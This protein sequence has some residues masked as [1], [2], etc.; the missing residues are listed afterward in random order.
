MLRRKLAKEFEIE[1]LGEL[2]YFLGMEVARLKKEIFV[3]QRKYVLDLLRET[4]MS[5]CRPADMSIDPKSEVR[6]CETEN[7]C[8][9]SAIST[10]NREIDLLVSYVLGHSFCS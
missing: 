8:E 6:R 10:T 1:D 7:P 2:H 3:S 5:G 4:G 9:Y